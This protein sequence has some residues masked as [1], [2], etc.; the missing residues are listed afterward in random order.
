M[1]ITY[2]YQEFTTYIEMKPCHSSQ[3]QSSL[4]GRPSI[5]YET[6]LSTIHNRINDLKEEQQCMMEIAVK[7][8]CYLHRNA[9]SPYNDDFIAYLDLFI[10]EEQ[11]KQTVD[12]QN[13]IILEELQH[14]SDQ[15]KQEIEL[16]RNTVPRLTVEEK[17]A[18]RMPESTLKGVREIFDLVKKLYALPIN[19]SLIREQVEGL[20]HGQ[21]SIIGDHEISIHVPCYGPVSAIVEQLDTVLSPTIVTAI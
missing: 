15:Y 20:K 12:H 5:S 9:I 11:L 3:Q 7:L 18:M 4:S 10:H 8:S 1:H 2:R 16:Y 21:S 13:D 6:W 19:G 17:F 14:L